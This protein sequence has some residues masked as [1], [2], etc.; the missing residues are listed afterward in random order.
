[1][2]AKKKAKKKVQKKKTFKEM[3]PKERRI[4]TL[5][6]VP[7]PLIIGFASIPHSGTKFM[8]NQIIPNDLP[9][10]PDLSR[11]SGGIVRGCLFY[12]L[13]RDDY[14]E[15]CSWLEHYPVLIPLRHPTSV[16]LSWKRRGK[17]TSILLKYWMRIIKMADEP[18]A[19]FL[20]I[21]S[22]DRNKWLQKLNKKT[23][24]KAKTKWPVIG[25]LAHRTIELSSNEERDISELI[26]NNKDFFAQF[27]YK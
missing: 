16:A 17:E 2:A 11:I 23:G 24:L 22:K 8:R 3:T 19:V 1:M 7:E 5:T 13:E 14:Q 4:H 25:S 12:H 9:H 10:I 15:I 20:P 6:Y 18:N 21:D 26:R 27:G